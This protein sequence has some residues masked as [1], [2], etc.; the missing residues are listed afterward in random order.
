MACICVSG[1]GK[2]ILTSQTFNAEKGNSFIF[3][4]T[5]EY[6]I[7]EGMIEIIIVFV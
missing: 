4:K 6:F 5:G 1:S 2:I 3:L 7:V